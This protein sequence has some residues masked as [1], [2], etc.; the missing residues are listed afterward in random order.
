MNFKLF[1]STFFN[2]ILFYT[3][4]RIIMSDIIILQSVLPTCEMRSDC[5]YENVEY[6]IIMLFLL[7]PCCNPIKQNI[8]R[9]LFV[10]QLF[11]KFYANLHP[12]IIFYIN[13]IKCMLSIV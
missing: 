10:I 13:L 9:K 1:Y 12:A 8:E 5:E 3:I 11:M 4:F 7:L 6:H 2:S